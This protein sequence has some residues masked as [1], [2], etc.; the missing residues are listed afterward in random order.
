MKQFGNFLLI[1][2]CLSGTSVSAQQRKPAPKPATSPKESA[3]PGDSSKPAEDEKSPEAKMEAKF[4]GLELRSIGPALISGRI[5]SIAVD[6]SNR[7]HYY[8]GAASGGVW[9]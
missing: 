8:V 6:P 5:V 1:L 4:A 3:K 2:L 9:K 7:A